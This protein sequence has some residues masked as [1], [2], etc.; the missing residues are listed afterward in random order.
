[1]SKQIPYCRKHKW[2]SFITKIYHGVS[3]VQPR[4]NTLLMHNIPFVFYHLPI[5]VNSKNNWWWQ[6]MP[7]FIDTEDNYSELNRQYF[8][9][10]PV[11]AYM[12]LAQS[13]TFFKNITC[14]KF[15]FVSRKATQSNNASSRPAILSSDSCQLSL[16]GFDLWLQNGSVSCACHRDHLYQLALKSVH[17]FWK[18]CVFVT[19][20]TEQ[21]MDAQTNGWTNGQKDRQM[22]RQV[23]KIISPDASLAWPREKHCKNCSRHLR[24]SQCNHHIFGYTA[25][26]SLATISPN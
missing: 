26:T 15:S 10:L 12:Y 5:I 19:L 22:N 2:I 11:S 4:W 6:R 1:M 8:Q 16:Q 17:S 23:Q 7:L 21:R 25:L 18:Y 14:W 20:L 24:L 9:L 3:F 13:K